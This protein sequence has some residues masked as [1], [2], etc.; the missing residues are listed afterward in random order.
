M[1]NTKKYKFRFYTEEGGPFSYY[2]EPITK[3]AYEYWN[4]NGGIAAL[5]NHFHEMVGVVTWERLKSGDSAA[6]QKLLDAEF[7]D[8]PAEARVLPSDPDSMQAES[9]YWYSSAGCDMIYIWNKR[10]LQNYIIEIY[11][12]STDTLVWKSNLE[13]LSQNNPSAIAKSIYRTQ[14]VEGY[15][16]HF[17]QDEDAVIIEHIEIA[18]EWDPSRLHIKLT[19][20]PVY[21]RCINTDS[22]YYQNDQ[23]ELIKLN[24]DWDYFDARLS[25]FL[26]HDGIRLSHPG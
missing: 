19:I 17:T 7:P 2:I 21:G 24:L 4:A 6:L 1:S 16:S 13:E 25:P 3:A 15:Y 14:Q 5:L 10:K 20:D 26:L 11:D 23:G 9:V 8:I 22:F 12:S 18:G